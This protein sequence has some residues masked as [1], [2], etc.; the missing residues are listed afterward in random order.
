MTLRSLALGAL[1]GTAATLTLTAPARAIEFEYGE[2]KGSLINTV[3]A[4]IQMRVAPRDSR[5]LGAANGGSTAISMTQNAEDNNK[6]FGQGDI[7]GAPVKLT[8][9]LN[10]AWRNLGIYGRGTAFYDYIYDNN[11]LAKFGDPT[12]PTYGR[13]STAA[14]RKAAMGAEVQDLFIRGE[15]DIGT[16]PLNV[17]VG[18]QTLNWGEALFTQNAISIINPLD[19]QKFAVPGAELRDGL[20]PVPMAW[21]SYEIVEGLAIEGFYQWEFKKLRLSPT[22]TYFGGADVIEESNDGIGGVSNGA[23]CNAS[24]QALPCVRQQANRDPGDSGNYGVKLNWYSEALNNTEFGFYYVRYTSRFPSLDYNVVNGGAGNLAELGQQFADD[25]TSQASYGRGIQMVAMSYNTTLEEPGI[26]VNGE[27]SYKMDVPGGIYGTTPYLEALCQYYTSAVGTCGNQ[28][29]SYLTN[30]NGEIPGSIRLDQVSTNFRLTKIFFAGMPFV[31][32]IGAESITV[33]SETSIN[34]ITNLPDSGELNMSPAITNGCGAGASSNAATTC[35]V[36]GATKV[37]SY[38]NLLLLVSYPAAFG[39]PINLT[40]GIYYGMTIQGNSPISAGPQRGFK[41]TNLS[42]KA[43]YQQN[44]TATLNFAKQWG[45]GYRNTNADKDF[46][47][48]TVN[49]TF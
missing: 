17:R 35:D 26:A 20:I 21:L 24:G 40:P 23:D 11:D 6:H 42:L 13:I 9:E 22:G 39:T 16:Q 30:T 31:S 7:V 1:V 29:S 12:S 8:T 48:L 4:G 3:S 15:F 25:L 19:L 32:G 41:A 47:G 18:Q 43:E 36:P 38:E 14:Q 44:L 2:F 45:G 46:V 33:V 10:V 27:F 49:Y 28:L 34:Y 5:F 37:S